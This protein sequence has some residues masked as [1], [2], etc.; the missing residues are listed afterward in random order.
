MS[1]HNATPDPTD[2]AL[3]FDYGGVLTTPVID[4]FRSWERRNGLEEGRFISL[5]R[6]AYTETDGG[7]VGRIERGE[8]STE[9][10]EDELAALLV[11]HDLR[12][13]GGVDIEEM[14]SEVEPVEDMW[15]VARTAADAGATVGLLSNS[16][17]MVAY[18]RERLDQ[19][20][21][22]QVISAEVGLRKPDP[23]I[24]DL[25]ARNVGLPPQ[26]CAFVDDL[27]ENV[28]VAQQLGMLGIVHEGD[29]AATRARLVDFLGL[30]SAP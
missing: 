7:P 1:T 29:A 12:V 6:G 11:E 19:Y 2:R 15:E 26:Q 20:F 13:P 14:L 18:P 9:Q 30:P 10:F 17:G 3:L 27:D 16:W 22:V 8:I 23:A 25:A 21:A 5:V 28:A 24:F 4:S